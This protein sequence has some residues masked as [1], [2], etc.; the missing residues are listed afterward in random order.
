MF[1]VPIQ[2]SYIFVSMINCSCAV[3][4]QQ[5]S[6]PYN[7]K[8]FRSIVWQEHTKWYQPLRPTT[9]RLSIDRSCRTCGH[10]SSVVA[11]RLLHFDWAELHWR[12]ARLTNPHKN[13]EAARRAVQRQCQIRKWGGNGNAVQS[14]ASISTRSTHRPVINV[15]VPHRRS[16]Y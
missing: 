8:M 5:L 3:L 10:L 2:L 11:L 16:P 4:L 1:F 14:A 12:V 9:S 13:Q 15:R 6:V 7:Q